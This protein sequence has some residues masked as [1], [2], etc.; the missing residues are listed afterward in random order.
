MYS[1]SKSFTSTGVGFAISEGKLK[2]TDQVISFFPDEL[3]ET[4]NEN[5]AAMQVQHLLSMS[6]WLYCRHDARN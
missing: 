4:I 3:P 1:V 5:L 2:L 6:W